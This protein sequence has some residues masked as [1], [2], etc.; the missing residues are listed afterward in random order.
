MVRLKTSF[1]FMPGSAVIFNETQSFF[2]TQITFKQILK[3]VKVIIP[4]FTIPFKVPVNLAFRKFL[5]TMN[6]S[7]GTGRMGGNLGP[8]QEVVAVTAVLGLFEN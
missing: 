6:S 3:I 8:N 4:K 5:R 1:E 7:L 2:R